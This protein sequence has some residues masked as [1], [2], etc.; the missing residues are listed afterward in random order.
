MSL[1]RSLAVA[2]R[3]IKTNIELYGNE[4]LQTKPG[5]MLRKTGPGAYLFDHLL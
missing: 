3:L 1:K 5:G 2:P 4:V